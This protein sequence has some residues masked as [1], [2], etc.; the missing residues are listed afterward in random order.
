MRFFST[1]GPVI[2]LFLFLPRF[3][4]LPACRRIAFNGFVSLRSLSQKKHPVLPFII[5]ASFV[6][7][8]APHLLQEQY[9]SMCPL[10]RGTSK[11]TR[12]LSEHHLARS[13]EFSISLSMF[14]RIWFNI[15]N[16][17]HHCSLSVK[18]IYIM[19]F[20]FASE[21][22]HIFRFIVHFYNIF[23]THCSLFINMAP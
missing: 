5:F 18:Q 10:D 23:P 12:Y 13:I 15:I 14:S 1:V 6:F 3:G 2:S 4:I 20:T 7:H 21:H 9:I 16:G 8:S 19:V 11:S 22:V 17:K